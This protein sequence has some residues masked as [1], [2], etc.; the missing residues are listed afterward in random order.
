MNSFLKVPQFIV[1]GGHK[2]A[3]SSLH[4]YLVQHPEIYM[5][6]IKG[7]DFFSREGNRGSIST[8]EEYKALYD[9]ITNE[10]VAGEV[11]SVY[12]YSQKA[13]QL[14]KEYNPDAKLIAI[15]RNPVERAI[16][17]FNSIPK[18]K[19]SNPDINKIINKQNVLDR[20]MYFQ[21]LKMYVDEF[22]RNQIE[23][24]LF[25]DLTKNKKKFFASF[26]EFIDVNPN[27]IPDT[28]LIVRKGGE[29][30]NKTIRQLF[31][32][33]SFLHSSA[34]MLLKPFTTSEQRRYL[35]K[36]VRNLFT[37]QKTTLSEDLRAKLTDV[38]REDILK[39][40]ELFD[41]D[42]SNWMKTN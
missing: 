3:T 9:G 30:K 29:I 39:V 34:G 11:S 32:K 15:L 10:K 8:I 5:P 13:C 18:K 7:T 6:S 14:I 1:L 42:L 41:I 33:Q 19:I 17:D 12:L 20:G 36:Q 16:S 31:D 22:S 26:F 24:L 27:F 38:Y 4:Y 21:V 40:Q 2:C 37:V 35:F 25:D 28:S 23:V